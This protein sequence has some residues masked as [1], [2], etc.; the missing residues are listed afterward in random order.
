MIV[1]GLNEQRKIVE[2]ELKVT[3]EG[4][5]LDD[6][7]LETDVDLWNRIYRPNDPNEGFCVA[8]YQLTN[9]CNKKCAYCYN[10]YLLKQH[11]GVVAVDKLVQSLEEFTPKDTRPVQR[12]RDYEF[13]GIHPLYAFIG[14]EPTVAPEL[15][16]FLHYICAT[17]NNKIYV[18]TNGINI[19]EDKHWIK[20]FPDTHQIMWSLSCDRDTT[21]EYIDKFVDIV[22]P[23]SNEYGFNL[24]IPES[25][26]GRDYALKLN[27]HMLQYHPEEIRYRG[28]SDQIEGTSAML[29]DVIK[30]V[31]EARDI[32]YDD[33]KKYAHFGHGG[34]VSTMTNPRGKIST[35]LLPI[36][37]RTFGEMLCK[38]GSYLINTYYFNTPGECHMNS[39]DLLKW[40]MKNSHLFIN[41]G[42]KMFWGKVNP[43]CVKA[44]KWEEVGTDYDTTKQR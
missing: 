15:P 14:G 28:L 13:D 31:A 7:L 22:G 27:D 30:F 4:V 38:W 17:R 40:R 25:E 19:T 29:S 37:K 5:Y 8:F 44:K 36:W 24:I 12:Y 23:R 11:P 1:H 3:D 32:T 6:V 42:V 34:F 20:Q 41:E 35:A 9:D 2:K 33:F 10:R 43:Y 39:A 16:A 26:S 18:Y 21:P